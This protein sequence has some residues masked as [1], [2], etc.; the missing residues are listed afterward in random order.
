MCGILLQPIVPRVAARL[1]DALRV[2]TGEDECG[3]DAACVGK[4][5]EQP[6]AMRRVVLV[7]KEGDVDGEG[8]DA[9]V[10]VKGGGVDGGRRGRG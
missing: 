10:N 3:L 2:G 9:N 6:G 4:G 8:G 5:R 1:L 7:P